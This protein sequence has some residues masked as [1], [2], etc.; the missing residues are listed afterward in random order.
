[1]AHNFTLSALSQIGSAARSDHNPI[2][3]LDG[4]SPIHVGWHRTTF[5]ARRIG[6]LL[7]HHHVIVSFKRA[8]GPSI[9]ADSVRPFRQ[10]DFTRFGHPYDVRSSIREGDLNSLAAFSLAIEGWHNEAHM[11]VGMAIGKSSQMMD[12]ARNIYLRE[13]WRLHYFIEARFLV[14]L[15]R[16]DR[17]GS[18][19]AKIARL[20]E[21]DHSRIGEI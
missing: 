3:F 19:S 21:G 17:A 12:P 4:L 20:E 15:S 14:A 8:R 1:M 5:H 10:S 18:T 7:F 11:A 9:W 2:E 16:L 13:F 6:F